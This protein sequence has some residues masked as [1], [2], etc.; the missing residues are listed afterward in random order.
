MKKVEASIEIAA[1][2]ERVWS[3]VSDLQSFPS[4]NPFMTRASGQLREGSRLE[5]TIEPPGGKPM[6]FKPRVLRVEPEREIRW[7]GRF[8]LPGLFDGEH[9]LRITPNASGGSTFTQSEKFRGILTWVSG[10]LFER[11]HSGFEAMNLA[12]K[13]RCEAD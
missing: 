11:T 5:I 2:P 9:S 13:E 10:K 3:V 4:W 1:A 6:T 8:L 7:L 12:L